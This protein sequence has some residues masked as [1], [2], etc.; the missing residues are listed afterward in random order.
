MLIALAVACATVGAAGL[1]V[2][3]PV[4]PADPEASGRD[5]AARLLALQPAEGMTNDATLTIRLHRTNQ[6]TVPL[7]I[8]VS[9]TETNWTTTYIQ[10]SSNNGSQARFTVVRNLDGA[11]EYYVQSPAAG[12]NSTQLLRGQDATVPIAG[13]DFCLG[14]V[15]MEFLRWPTQR[16]VKKEVRRTQSCDKLESI[17]PAGWTNGYVRVL[18]WFDIDTG[19][20]VI[21]EAYDARGRMVKEFKPNNFKKVD[22]QYQ[23]EEIEMNDLVARSRSTIRFNLPGK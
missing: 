5:L 20:P 17:A 10:L 14:D 8:E 11:N 3:V 16:L 23:V 19:G 15:G 21:V 7:R 4:V 1:P 12:P 13:S 18:S 6:L 22:G 9:V 2:S